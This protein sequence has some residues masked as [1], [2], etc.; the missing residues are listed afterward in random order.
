MFRC[1]FLFPGHSRRAMKGRRLRST[2][3]LRLD[4]FQRAGRPLTERRRPTAWDAA[5]LWITRRGGVRRGAGINLWVGCCFPAGGRQTANRSAAHH[6]PRLPNT[7]LCC[8]LP[9]G[10]R[11]PLLLTR[12][13]VSLQSPSCISVCLL[14]RG[15][16]AEPGTGLGV[17]PA[18]RPP[19]GAWDGANR[20]AARRAPEGGYS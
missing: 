4:L 3:S 2:D 8:N 1:H 5:Y 12:P 13:P 16:T 20:R 17:G 14:H 19:D 11:V 18:R 6:F 10:P 15:P 9:R 7:T